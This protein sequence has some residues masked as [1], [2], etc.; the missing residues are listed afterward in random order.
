[1]AQVVVRGITFLTTPLLTRI[2]TTAEFGVVKVYES[3]IMLLTPVFTLCLYNSVARARFDFKDEFEEY[4]SSIQLL[5]LPFAA[6]V[7][8]IVCFCWEDVQKL[9]SMDGIMLVTFLLYMPTYSFVSIYQ[10][11]E[12]QLMRYKSNIIVSAIYAVP[13][14][15]FSV[16]LCLFAKNGGWSVGLVDV[17][18]ISFYVP[19]IIVGIVIAVI[20]CAKGR[21]TLKLSHWRYALKFSLPLIP[22]MLSLYI[23]SQCD[24]LMIKSMCGDS[25][26]GIFSL[27]VTIQYVLFILIDAVEGAWTPWLFDRLDDGEEHKIQKPWLLLLVGAGVAALLIGLAAPELVGILGGRDYAQA[28]YIVPPLLICTM[29]AFGSRAFVGIEKFNKKTGLTAVCTIIVAVI[30]IPLNYVFI[31]LYGYIAA[32][33]TTAFCYLLLLIIHGLAVRLILKER[34]IRLWTTLGITIAFSAVFLA[35]IFLYD[36]QGSVFIRYGCIIAVIAAALIVM[37]KSIVQYIKN[38]KCKKNALIH[39]GNNS[40]GE[41]VH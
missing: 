41:N 12:R 6:A 3:W 25:Q 19:Q 17:R 7:A 26:A 1:M 9:M 28:V 24:R 32:A 13:A 33:Y 10:A 8:A 21:F 35:V 4:C 5:C 39:N 31:K 15:I 23:L 34:C 37:R 20:V 29:L 30:N 22:H 2:L 18:I 36:V 14:T 27:A 40:G 11:H 38:A 16:L